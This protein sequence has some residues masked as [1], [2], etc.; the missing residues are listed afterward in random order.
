MLFRLTV[1]LLVLERVF[2]NHAQSTMAWEAQPIY[3]SN[4]NC[5]SVPTTLLDQQPVQVLPCDGSSNQQWDG[6]TGGPH[7]QDAGFVLLVASGVPHF[8]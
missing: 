2:P 7:I 6:V 5:L 4:G 1:V 8:K 3:T